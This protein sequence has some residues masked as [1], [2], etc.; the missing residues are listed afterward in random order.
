MNL[1]FSDWAR[2]LSLAVLVGLVAGCHSEPAQQTPAQMFREDPQRS[3]VSGQVGPAQLDEVIWQF[4]GDEGGASSPVISGPHIYSGSYD[5]HLYAVDKTT[6]RKQWQFATGAGIFST[7][8]I[9][10]E[11]IVFGSDDGSV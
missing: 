4:A 6:G 3:G 8:A 2:L 7:P 10:G 11:S 9:S 5:G 1:Q